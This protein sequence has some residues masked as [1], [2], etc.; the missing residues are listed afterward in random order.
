MIGIQRLLLIAAGSL[1]GFSLTL[2]AENAV[3]A[4]LVDYQ[5]VRLQLML[6]IGAL[7]TNQPKFWLADHLA[8]FVLQETAGPARPAS[9][10]QGVLPPEE[11]FK[12]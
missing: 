7:D 1:M 11:Y 12:N 2:A 9:A 5:Q 4:A 6:D 3:T 10:D 8:G